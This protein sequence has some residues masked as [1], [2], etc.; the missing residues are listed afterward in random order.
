[1]G[2]AQQQ[3]AGRIPLSACLRQ[4][5]EVQALEKERR[6]QYTCSKCAKPSGMKSLA[7]RRQWIWPGDLPPLLMLH[8]QR[9][10]RYGVRLEKSSASVELPATLD[11][12]DHALSKDEL[13]GIRQ[14]VA[15]GAEA[16]DEIEDVAAGSLL[17]ELYAVCVHQGESMH[18]GHYVV[19]VNA[20]DSLGKPS[21]RGVDD[22]KVW[23]CEL[24]EV[25]K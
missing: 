16:C 18:F 5:S 10:R 9:F 4:F 13:Q 7:S 23:R 2:R 6:P 15:K 11:L 22:G 3:G 1:M 25:L 8:L 19:Y 14:Y 24:E 12:A 21:W 17:Y 20:G